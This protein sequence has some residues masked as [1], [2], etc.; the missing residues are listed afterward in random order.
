MQRV[1]PFNVEAMLGM[2][3][4]LEKERIRNAARIVQQHGRVY[5]SVRSVL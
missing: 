1:Y 3:M 2:P 4:L 5:G